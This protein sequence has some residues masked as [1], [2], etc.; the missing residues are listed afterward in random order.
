[1]T[2]P[3]SPTS[4]LPRTQQGRQIQGSQIVQPERPLSLFVCPGVS[5]KRYDMS[6]EIVDLPEFK[7]IMVS[8]STLMLATQQHRGPEEREADGLRCSP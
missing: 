7:P 5:F 4:S 1:M 2:D 3:S 6:R 8:H